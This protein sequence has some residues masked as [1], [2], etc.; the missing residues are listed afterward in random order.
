MT[1][2][3]IVSSAIK[4]F[5]LRLPG[6][7]YLAN[8][9]VVLAAISDG[10]TRLSN[11]PRNDD[12][13][14]ALGAIQAL[15]AKVEWLDQT[16]VEIKGIESFELADDVVIDCHDS[17]TLAR[18]ITAL[19]GLFYSSVGHQ[20]TI[21]GSQQM[22]SRPMQESVASLETLGVSIESEKGFLPIKISGPITGGSCELDASRSSQF[23]SGL[24]IACLKAEKDTLIHLSSDA[25]S[26]SY[27]EL[28]LRAIELFGG[29][30]KRINCREFFIPGQ[31]ALVAKDIHVAGDVVSSSYFLAAGLLA[32]SS[33]TVLNYH[34]DSP[35]GESKFPQV[36]ERM[37]AKVYLKQDDLKVE[38]DSP[39]QGIDVDMGNMP[40]VVPTL[41][42]L[43]CFAQGETRITNIAHLAFKESNRI[44]DLCEQLKKLGAD[45][46]YD[47]SSITIR[48]GKQLIADKVS[49]CHDHRLAMSL[50]LIGIK[51]KGLTIESSE[52]VA[53][54]FPDYWQ[55]L[56]QIGMV[57]ELVLERV[58]ETVSAEH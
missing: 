9:Y 35:Q 13:L 20:I 50:A 52:A 24:L 43:A 29:E 41:A 58:S 26:E 22:R 19:T 53:K 7:K 11:V 31:Q 6:S 40:D 14:A 32:E 23:L 21:T 37:G 5:E 28:T 30:V 15:G 48:G 36:L 33:C 25:V 49:S 39:L 46:E 18:F 38:Y 1:D 55:Y 45:C 17:G 54:S 47:E 34:F 16:S 51:L 8:R 12:I 2:R 4:P 42:A 3:I 44:V 10:T 56:E 57:T 27:V